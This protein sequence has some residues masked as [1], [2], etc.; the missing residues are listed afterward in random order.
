MP[1]T[2]D[3]TTALLALTMTDG[4]GPKTL[5]NLLAA[6][7]DDAAA[8]LRA[9]ADD[10]RAHGV[11]EKRAATLARKLAEARTH[12]QT[13]R[14]A[15]YREQK[16]ACVTA[17]Q[18][19]YPPLLAH[20]P[21]A[22]PLLFVRAQNVAVL[23]ASPYVTIVGARNHTAYGKRA[24]Y[25]LAHDLAQRGVCVVSGMARGIDTEAHRGAIAGGGTTI[26]VLGGSVDDASIY[27]RQNH[28]L[29]HD[30]IAHGAVISAYPVPTAPTR[31]TFPARNR[32]MAAMSHVTVIIEC[33]PKSGTM[34]TA[35]AAAEY[36]RDVG[37]VPGTIFS[38]MST[39]P[40]TLL[41]DGAALIATADDVMALLPHDT[42]AMRNVPAPPPED[43]SDDEQ[44]IMAVIGADALHIDKIIAQSKLEATRARTA[45]SL[46]EIKGLVHD[47]GAGRIAR[48]T[49][50]TL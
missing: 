24:A 42:P 17:A 50:T 34:I 21:D 23:T 29:A 43:L 48:T 16:I 46:L 12:A 40:H 9:D 18:E 7:K 6:Y 1:V 26:A 4:L 31:Y 11:T 36:G 37:A 20:A 22:P 39:G 10:L 13:P 25:M 19:M 41:R 35:R 3:N 49:N 15:A 8:L 30:I 14:H 45:L 47:T 44:R 5:N 2:T 33:T 38:D 32:I 28:R 27:P